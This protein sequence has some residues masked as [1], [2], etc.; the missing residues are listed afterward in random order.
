MAWLQNDPTAIPDDTYPFAL[1]GAGFGDVFMSPLHGAALAAV[2]AVIVNDP[3]W[4]TRATWLGREAMRLYLERKD[5]G[6]RDRP[7]A[8][9]PV[10]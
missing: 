9:I 8:S 7:A 2:A 5:A 6:L 1:A 10:H 3:H 4:R